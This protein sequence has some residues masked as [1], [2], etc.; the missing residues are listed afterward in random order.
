MATYGEPDW[1]APG[2]SANATST[3]NSA[4]TNT[5]TGLAPGNP[6]ETT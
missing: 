5:E 3:S 1:A 2:S 4:P 6:V